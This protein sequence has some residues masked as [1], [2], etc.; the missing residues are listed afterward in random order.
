MYNVACGQILHYVFGLLGM[1]LFATL[2]S[3]LSSD[4]GDDEPP[5]DFDTM[6]QAQRALAQVSAMAVWG[7]W[8]E[9]SEGK[10]RVRA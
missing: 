4:N 6:F 1:W 9:G 10:G 3:G 7:R 8:R 2:L 5:V